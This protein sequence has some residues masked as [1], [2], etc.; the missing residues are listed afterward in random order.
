MRRPASR[1]GPGG[2]G[3]FRCTLDVTSYYVLSCVDTQKQR[4]GSVVLYR[5][6]V[7]CVKP[8]YTPLLSAPSTPHRTAKKQAE[9]KP[10][11][12]GEQQRS[13]WPDK[14]WP[15]GC[16]CP[17]GCARL[18][19]LPL[20][21]GCRSGWRNGLEIARERTRKLGNLPPP[22][23]FFFIGFFSGFPIALS[24]YSSILS[25]INEIAPA[26]TR[27]VRGLGPNLI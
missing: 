9:N 6:E 12:S 25:L 23:V 17:M 3:W 22:K 8:L 20:P 16:A 18:G 21:P 2:R 24:R 15:V 19:F 10:Q 26:T 7:W 27:I 14:R 11:T 4:I 13:K 1:L 5:P